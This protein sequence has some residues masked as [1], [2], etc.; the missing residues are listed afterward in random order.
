MSEDKQRTLKQNKSYWKWLEMMT[1]E[2]NDAGYSVQTVLEKAPK[3]S[4]TKENFHH[5]ISKG[6]IKALFLKSSSTQ[7]TTK[8]L[9]LLQEE[10]TRY[11]A[12]N[13]GIQCDWPSIESMSIKELTK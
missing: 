1:D 5:N 6:L 7:L 11:L 9:M 12:E 13:V 3:L 2:L 4:F 10:I 8:E